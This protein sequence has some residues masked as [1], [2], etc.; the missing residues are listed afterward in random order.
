MATRDSGRGALRPHKPTIYLP[1]KGFRGTEIAKG[2][3]WADLTQKAPGGPRFSTRDPHPFQDLETK[4]KYRK[5]DDLAQ[6]WIARALRY[7]DIVSRITNNT[8]TAPELVLVGR[9]LSL[10]FTLGYNL[11]FQTK[12]LPGFNLKSGKPFTVDVAIEFGGPKYMPV[13]GVR[14]HKAELQEIIADALRDN[15][16]NLTG[17]VIPVYDT[18]CL[19]GQRLTTY[20]HGLG[21]P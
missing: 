12:S 19:Y 5:Y 1:H 11:F 21:A 18:E 7:N 4:D 14:F 6:S 2:P 13:D 16:L 17:K 15:R 8:G 3:S 10:G 9:Y 20:L